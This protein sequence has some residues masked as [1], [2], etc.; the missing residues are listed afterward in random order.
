M[1]NP[2]KSLIIEYH[3]IQSFPVSCLNRDDMGSPKTA[4][5]GGVERA[6]VSSQCWKYAVR[7]ELHNIGVTMGTRTKKLDTALSD[8]LIDQG[9]DPELAITSSQLVGSKISNDTLIFIS[10]KEIK[11]LAAMMINR[12]FDLKDVTGTVGKKS[13]PNGFKL[14]SEIQKIIKSVMSSGLDAIDV[15]LFGRMVAKINDINMEGACSF[16]HAISTHKVDNEIDFFTGHDDQ[17]Q[18]GVNQAAHIGEKEFNSATYYRYVTLNVG[19]L[20][21]N[22][23]GH[24]E[25]DMTVLNRA[26]E[27]FTETL[28]TTIP[29]ARH[30]SMSAYCPWDF[31]RI[32][33]R[34]GQAI[35]AKY[36]EPVTAVRGG[37]FSKPSINLLK[38]QLTQHEK[39]LGLRRYG[40]VFSIDIGDQSDS[41]LDD[42][43][44]GLS[45]ALS[46]HYETQ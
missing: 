38:Q 31:G 14:E 29:E 11:A 36:E 46:S 30:N 18:P 16:A 12:K 37:G 7:K 9:V 39:T 3:I 23:F 28:Y 40:Q 13:T 2:F 45:K 8:Y 44:V 35:Q 26:I 41:S 19:Q 20:A 22:L 4:M 33:V 43:L 5:V 1:N 15:A 10:E 6:R 42:V 32:T 21:D 27:A 24:A 17:N 25:I 34:K